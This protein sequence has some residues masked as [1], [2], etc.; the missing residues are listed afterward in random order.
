MSAFV[1]WL[2]T[3]N[4]LHVRVRLT[5]KSSRQVIEGLDAT[6][7]GPALSVRVRALP[8]DGQ[9]NAALEGLLAAWMQVPRRT[10]SV[11]SGGKSRL[12]IVAIAGDPAVLL[13]IAVRAL[14]ATTG[15]LS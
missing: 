12:K 3:S 4:G 15:D 1:P 5:P 13:A 9:A 6:A 8:E 2:L 11:H 10:V 7:H 14:A